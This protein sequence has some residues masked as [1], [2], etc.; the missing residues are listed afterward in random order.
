MFRVMRCDHSLL[1]GEWLLTPQRKL[2]GQ[3]ERET[4]YS[5]FTML[6][7]VRL[8]N[9]TS[10]IPDSEKSALFI[11]LG[12][13]TSPTSFIHHGINTTIVELDP[14]VHDFAVKYFALPPNHTAVIQDA[15]P[16]VESAALSQPKSFDYIIHDVFT[17]GAE[18]TPLFT[19]EFLHGLDTLL[20]DD[21]VVAIN[22]AGDIAMPP[23]RLILN[24]I[25]A[26]FPTC[27]I[28]RDSPPEEGAATFINMVVFCTRRAGEPI[29]FRRAV[30]G[31]WLGSLSRREFVPPSERLEMRLEDVKGA[32]G[33][34]G[35]EEVLTRGQEWRVEKYHL[36][37]A[38][39]HWR[40][41][42]TVLPD[43]V[44]EN[45]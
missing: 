16:F 25:H 17:G 2:R 21:G 9:S 8:V 4:I 12:I 37:A 32:G 43:G 7:A 20:K 15:V 42:R 1:G 18:P 26:V 31:D 29:K 27:R 39:R 3:T 33:E 38:R 36:E 22:Y 6:E 23:P 11:G 5:V 44:W 41:M 24:T 45:W 40:I 28:Y 35:R 30:D 10:Q 19:R 34:N 13:G 14:A